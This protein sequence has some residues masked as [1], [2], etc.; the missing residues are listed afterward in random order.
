MTPS[1]DGAYPS[2]RRLR[3]ALECDGARVGLT[4]TW[5]PRIVMNNRQQPRQWARALPRHRA[6]GRA[7]RHHRRKPSGSAYSLPGVGHILPQ[8]GEA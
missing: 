3:V 1:R 7:S 4:R 8:L 5:V 6:V 2:P